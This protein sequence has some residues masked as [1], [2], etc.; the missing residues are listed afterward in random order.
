MQHIFTGIRNSYLKISQNIVPG[1][2]PNL[3]ATLQAKF[4]PAHDVLLVIAPDTEQE[5]TPLVQCMGWVKFMPNICMN[6]VQ[7]QAVDAI[8]KKHS[9]EEHGADNLS[10]VNTDP[11]LCVTDHWANSIQRAVWLRALCVDGNFTEAA[12]F[13][14][15]LAKLK[16][17]CNVTSLLEVLLD[18]DKDTDSVHADNY[19]CVAQIHECVLCLSPRTTFNFIYEM[20]QYASSL[21][22]NQVKEP[23]VHVDADIKSIIIST[24]TMEMD[25]LQEGIQVILHDFKQRCSALMDENIV[26]KH[27]PDHVKYAKTIAAGLRYHNYSHSKD[28]PDNIQKVLAKQFG[29]ISMQIILLSA[30]IPP[31]HLKLFIKPFGLKAKDIT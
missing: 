1:I 27:M 9:P 17:L 13:T 19:D 29:N 18:K 25:K 21:A 10:L 16:Y 24:Q 15:D 7:R 4:L 30:T 8:K 3:K 6:P 11:A 26:L 23:N 5:R 22:F 31:H 14:P 28:M 20:Q 2:Q 12:Y